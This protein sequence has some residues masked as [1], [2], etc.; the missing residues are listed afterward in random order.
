MFDKCV[1]L[2]P[3]P[4]RCATEFLHVTVRLYTNIVVGTS[5]FRETRSQGLEMG[6]VI[7]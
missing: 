1:T 5:P 3:A 7:I 2:P 6:F 4:N